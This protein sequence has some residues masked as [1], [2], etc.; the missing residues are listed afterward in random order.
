MKLK[1]YKAIFNGFR[2]LLFTI[3]ALNLSAQWTSKVP[4]I[5]DT[6]WILYNQIIDENTVWMGGNQYVFD[7][8]NSLQ[9]GNFVSIYTT[10]NGGVD[11]K[12]KKLMVDPESLPFLTNITG[13][14]GQ[15]AW[16]SIYQ[17]NLGTNLILKSDD[18]GESWKTTASNLFT[19][20]SSFLN[21]ISF[22]DAQNGIMIGDPSPDTDSTDYYFEIYHT[23]DGGLTWIRIPQSQ[24]PDPLED[25]YGI[26]GEFSRVGDNIWFSTD[27]GRIIYSNDGGQHWDVSLAGTGYTGFLNFVDDLHGI[28]GSTDSIF[29]AT[30]LDIKYTEDGGLHWQHVESPYKDS[31]Y[32]W[33]L[34]LI[35]ES[36]FILT[37]HAATLQ[38]APFIT[39]LTK[40][41]GQ[42]WIEIGQADGLSVAQFINPRVGYAGE[43]VSLNQDHA[44]KIF[45]Y[46]G[47]PLTGLLSNNQ[48]DAKLEIIPNPV[49]DR[50][51][52]NIELKE[53]SA[54][55]LILNNSEGKL[56]WETTITENS[57][58]HTPAVD[59][60]HLAPGTYLLTLSSPEGFLTKKI[61]KE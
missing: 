40:D 2:L 24:I 9:L 51:N 41:K 22:K 28:C 4:Q 21:G 14:N 18:G 27:Q 52:L 35:P 38:G 43:G 31:T 8:A 16:A 3:C 15:S 46:A 50:M 45:K 25:E 57:L 39:W 7:T 49:I 55:K 59:V 19:D 53:P 1:F 20:P 5:N 47:D 29:S 33:S 44:T 54:L 42:S 48:L 60:R 17:L 37:T 58:H 10:S 61:I 26:S 23:T 32:F 56:M 11:W 6:V 13:I 12:Y 36:N 30:A 34:C